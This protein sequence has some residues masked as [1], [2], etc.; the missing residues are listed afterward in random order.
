MNSNRIN[1][2]GFSLIELLVVIAIIAVLIALLL[3][4]VQSAREAARRTQCVNNLKQIGLA[5]HNY[6]SVEQTFPVFMIPARCANT[7]HNGSDIWGPSVFVRLLNYMEGTALSNAFNFTI[8]GTFGCPSSEGGALANTTVR[9]SSVAAF[10]CPSDFATPRTGGNYAPSIGPQ[11]N[12]WNLTSNNRGL[13]LGMFARRSHTPL[14]TVTDGL[15]NT[16][17]IGEQLKGGN[18]ERR[19]GGAD[20]FLGVA[21]P[22]GEGNGTSLASSMPTGLVNLQQFQQDCNLRRQNNQNVGTSANL[23]WAA[24]R[25]D[26]GPFMNT[27]QT[28]NSPNADCHGNQAGGVLGARSRHP[29]GVNVLLCDGSVRFIKDTINVEVWWALSTRNRGEVI[30]ASDF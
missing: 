2:S 12:Y 1:R 3:P 11:Y 10:L 13:G 16:L 22:G 24:G 20:R 4:A 26:V 30:S 6:E 21:W 19:L 27:L 28:P 8:S 14:N 17:V 29:G 9:E 5:L 7:P 25:A 18:G 23:F 15:S